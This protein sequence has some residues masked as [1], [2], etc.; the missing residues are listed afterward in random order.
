MISLTVKSNCEFVCQC[1]GR[2]HA[3]DVRALT[4]FVV[5]I[6]PTVLTVNKVP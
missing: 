1:I 2:C 3:E 6:T 4:F 5:S